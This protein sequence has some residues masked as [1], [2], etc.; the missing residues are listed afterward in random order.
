[1]LWRPPRLDRQCRSLLSC[2]PVPSEIAGS[3]AMAIVSEIEQQIVV[4]L[5]QFPNV[6]L[7]HSGEFQK[8]PAEPI[9]D[10]ARDYLG[11]IPYT[12]LFYAA[13]GLILARKIHVLTNLPYKVVVLDCDNTIWS[14]IVGEDGPSGIVISTA[15]KQMQQYMVELSSKGFLL[16]LCSKN[17]EADVLDVFDK[18]ADMILKRDHLVSW[19]INWRPKSENIKSLARELKLGLDSFIFL[20]D[21]PVELRGSAVG[22]PR[23]AHAAGSTRGC[24]PPVP[25][26]CLG[27]RSRKNYF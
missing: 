17:D 9:H 8:Y 27:V 10:A 21:N 6:H 20:D 7:I 25:G 3:E 4:S 26:S 18:R 11:H 23:G 2:V 5:E 14:G 12:P 22:V 1:M 19:R 15:W 24:H 16:C 13:L